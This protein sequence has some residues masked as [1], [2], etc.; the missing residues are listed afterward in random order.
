MC[1]Y[2]LT[3]FSKYLGYDQNGMKGDVLR[4]DKFCWLQ[5]LFWYRKT[6]YRL[7][8]ILNKRL[9]AYLFNFIHLNHRN[10]LV[11]FFGTARSID[12]VRVL[13]ESIVYTQMINTFVY[14]THFSLSLSYFSKFTINQKGMPYIC[15]LQKINLHHRLCHCLII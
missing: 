13:K 5:S 9:S 1:Y 4:V 8:G 10:L 15:K 14:F 12:L 3:S 6:H 11:C 7:W 2:L